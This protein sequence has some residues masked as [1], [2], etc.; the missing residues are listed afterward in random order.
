MTENIR[1]Q[2]MIISLIIFLG[3]IL[4]LGV[5]FTQWW[6]TGDDFHGVYLGFKATSWHDLFNFFYEGHTNQGAGSHFCE[7]I[8]RPSF[9][10]AYYRP[11]YCIFITLQYWLLGLNIYGYFLCN[12]VMHALNTTLLFRI[13]STF[14][15]IGP[16]LAAALLFAV[17]PQIG[18]RFGAVVNFHYYVNVACILL[19]GICIK[20]YFDTA[21]K[22]YYFFAAILYA[23]SLCTRETTIVLP[24]I[25][26]SWYALFGNNQLKPS[27]IQALK[28]TPKALVKT[29]WFWIIALAFLG[30]RAY[31]YP[32]VLQTNGLCL[33]YVAHGNF[34][35]H[36]SQ[37]FLMMLYDILAL[38]WLPWGNRLLKVIIIAPTFCFFAWCWLKSTARWYI[39]WC[40][41]SMVAMLWPGFISYYSPRYLYEAYPFGLLGMLLLVHSAQ[42]IPQWIKRILLYSSLILVSLYSLLAVYNLHTRSTKM[43][44]AQLATIS[45]AKELHN[46]TRPLCFMCIPNDGFAECFPHDTLAIMFNNKQYPA[47]TDSASFITQADANIVQTLCCANVISPYYKQNYY[48]ITPVPGGIRITSLNA[49]KVHFN[50]A[51]FAQPTQ[52]GTRII[53]NRARYKNTTVITDFSLIITPDLMAQQPLFAHWDYTMQRFATFTLPD[54]VLT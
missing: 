8:H 3:I 52:L 53:H 22:S 44:H 23:I 29:A 35:A 48:T 37:E 27:F 51:D 1:H 43:Q 10:G 40:F 25:I 2:K 5:P 46:S 18:Y 45:L 31:L 50:E 38:S 21:H 15:K 36:K 9:L 19:I 32:I 12:V 14:A 30:L 39:F 54:H 11:L 33:P 41:I 6:L 24:A 7:I 4:I 49:N 16:A 42:T 28:N 47:F 17:H 13:F 26:T 34:I 20:K